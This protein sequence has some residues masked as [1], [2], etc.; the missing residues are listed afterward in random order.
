MIYS[1]NKNQ[2]HVLQFNNNVRIYIYIYIYIQGFSRLEDIIAGGDFLGLSD[3]KSSYKHVSDY[4][5]LRSY[6]R[7]KL[8]REGNDY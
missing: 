6:N 1:Y 2:Q 7:L 5:R 3:Q 8:R 4:G